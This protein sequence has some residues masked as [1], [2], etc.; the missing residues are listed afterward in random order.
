MLPLLVAVALLLGVLGAES[1]DAALQHPP[2]RQQHGRRFLSDAYV[3]GERADP[4]ALFQLTIGLHVHDF[5][6]LERRLWHVS[7]PQNEAYGRHL[8]KQEADELARPKDGA[9][10]AVQDWVQ[11]Y[12]DAVSFSSASNTVKVSMLVKH[13]EALLG[14]EMHE[15]ESLRTNTDGRPSS[16]ILRAASDFE[17]PAHLHESI[18]YLNVNAHPLGLRALATAATTATAAKQNNG[19]TLE[20]I[21]NVYGIPT[22]LVVTNETN[23]QCVPSFYTESYNPDDLEKF[24]DSFLPDASL[25]VVIEKGNRAND[26]TKP[27]IEASLDIQ[28]ITGVARNATTYLWTMGG[29]N[30]YSAKDEPFVEFVEAVL[31]MDRPP[32]VVSISYSDDEEEV[33]KLAAEYAQVFDT[34]L[35][36]MGLRGITVLIASGDDG[37]A[38]LRPEFANLP[39]NET[40]LKAGPQWPSASPYITS[41]GATMQLPPVEFSKN[42]FR[43]DEEVVCSG[44]TGGIVTGGGGFSNVYSIPEYQ[45][46]AVARYLESNRIPKSPG[47]F[48]KTGRAY[49]DISALG[50]SYHTYVHGGMTAVSGTSASTPVVGAM[51]TLWNDARLNAGKSPL[52]FINPLL[53]YMAEVHPSAFHDVV[54][55]NNGARKGGILVCEESF[56]AAGGWDAATG[57][58]TPNFPVFRD[59]VLALDDHFNIS[60]PAPALDCE[61]SALSKMNNSAFGVNGSQTALS[62]TTGNGDV[63][64]DAVQG[65]SSVLEIVVLVTAIV[66]IGAVTAMLLT[67]LFK[68]WRNQYTSL[69]ADAAASTT[70]RAKNSSSPRRSEHNGQDDSGDEDEDEV[71]DDSKHDRNDAEL[72]EISLHE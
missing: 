13:A 20:N 14:I 1:V 59:F 11:S 29:T 42:F 27:T 28:Y 32:Y 61:S 26:R 12:S 63:V 19:G 16:R 45:K 8:S 71:K 9:L 34:L 35:I 50:A 51:V 15:Y 67:T 23:T 3:Q 70:S 48:N 36:K 44:E 31:E 22:D 38:G 56:G 60:T 68:R 40:C 7:S 18:A 21:R 24:Y 43:T 4:N 57:V 30:P 46:V 2:S 47:Y 41:V 6:A 33:Y 10:E 66:G 58:G 53:Y 64:V 62:D 17:I 39:S 25:P 72:S 55:G 37:V 52:G 54:V 69:N 49:P 65:H 5:A